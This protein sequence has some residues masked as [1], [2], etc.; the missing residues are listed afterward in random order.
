[1]PSPF[2][3]MD[4]WL[5]SPAIFPDLHN[6]L[7]TYLG[8]AL[9][10]VLPEP[11]FARSAT[12]VWV[13]QDHP[14]EPDVSLLGP[15]V[16]PVRTGTVDLVAAMT[17]AGMIAVE[18][19]NYHPEPFEEPFLEVRSTADD[20]LVTAIEVLSLANKSPGDKGREAYRQKQTEYLIEGV[21]LV[22]I[23]LLRGG[24]HTTAVPRGRLRSRAGFFDY[25]L[26]VS[27]AVLGRQHFVAPIRLAD[28][29][30]TLSV[31]LD[32]DAEPVT[33]DLQPLLDRCYDN[34]RYARQVRY[35]QPPDPPLTDEQ[36]TWAEG[37][38]RQKGLLP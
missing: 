36:R 4:P 28:R 7:I 24:E 22:E 14:R 26:C 15:S 29:L 25:H 31:P 23:D 38:L 32:R 6:T 13:E 3:G 9:N 10:A 33:V 19:P 11:Y 12:R 8:D 20:R 21:G 30:P 35:T 16:R 37:I 18:D 5:E 1:M 34:R 27:G 17:A 2:P